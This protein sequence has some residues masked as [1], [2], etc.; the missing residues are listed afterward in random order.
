MGYRSEVTI[1]IHDDACINGDASTELPPD[2][3][4]NPYHAG[5]F[6]EDGFYLRPGVLSESNDVGKSKKLKGGREDE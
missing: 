2:L 5:T 3:T 4:L 6:W 1:A